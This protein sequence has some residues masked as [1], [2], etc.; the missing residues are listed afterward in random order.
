MKSEAY[1]EIIVMLV[2]VAV[3]ATLQ[4][5]STL[6]AD[7]AKVINI[8]TS[9]YSTGGN[10]GRDGEDGQDGRSGV[11]GT[12]IVNN[13]SGSASIRIESNLNGS[14]VVRVYETKSGNAFVATNIHATP[15]LLS[16]NAKED[17]SIVELETADEEVVSSIEEMFLSIR[18]LMLHYVGKI[19]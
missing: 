8:A 19:F 9:H 7:P 6:A 3:Y 18:S 16:E 15:T 5:A 14:D 11:S 17:D 2:F 13:G 4:T 12:S 10:S 1:K